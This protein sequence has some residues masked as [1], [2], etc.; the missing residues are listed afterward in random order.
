MSEKITEKFELYDVLGT[1]VPGLVAVG[2]IYTALSWTGHKVEIPTMP[3][4]LQVLVL[5]A[6]AIVLGQ[7][8]QTLGSLLEGFY[9]W[10][11]RGRPSDR[12]L[13]GKSRRMSAS[14]SAELKGR[15]NSHFLGNAN[16]D[17]SDHEIFLCA[18]SICNHRSL[19]RVARFNSL[20][21]YHRALTTLLLTS[22]VTTLVI[23]FVVEPNPYAAWRVFI[24]EA[25]TTLLF[26]YRTKQRGMYFADEA[27]RMADLEV[28]QQT[29]AERTNLASQN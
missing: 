14:Q 5:S 1:L 13:Q 4:A 7:L 27:L 21:A 23:I 19:G 3:E 26:W 22:T 11:W 16:Q 18:L 29:I 8:V 28:A 15:L 12:A 17:M 20:Y 6:V 9:F 10:T 2:L 24:L 25:A